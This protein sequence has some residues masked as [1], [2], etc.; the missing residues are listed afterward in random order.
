MDPH[1]LPFEVGQL[2][3]TRSFLAGYRGAWFRCKIKEIGRRNKELG[4]ALEY[5]DFPDESSVAAT[6]P[7]PSLSHA[8]FQLG[9][10]LWILQCL[11]SVPGNQKNWS[12]GNIG[13]SKDGKRTLMVRPCFPPVYREN[14]MPDV[15]TISEVIVIINDVWKVGDLVDWWIDNC[16]WSGRITEKLGDE[17]VKI[18]LPPPPVGEGSSYEVLC[19]DL[20]PSLDWSVSEGWKLLLPKVAALHSFSSLAFLSDLILV[21]SRLSIS[22]EFVQHP[23]SIDARRHNNLISLEFKKQFFGAKYVL[24]SVDIFYPIMSKENKYHLCCARIV[25]SLNRGGSPN[26]IDHT[27]SVRDKDAQ[28]TA[29]ASVEHEGSLSSHIS[30]GPLHLPYKRLQL[31][32]KSLNEKQT[33]TKEKIIGLTVV[34]HVPRKT[35]CSDSVSSSPIQDTS[36]QMP[37]MAIQSDK[38][39][40]N[41]LKKMKI[42]ERI[43]LNSTSSDTIEAAILD[44]EELICRVKWL[45]HILE[46]GTP[47]SDSMKSSWKFIEHRASRPK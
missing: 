16:F 26:L 33:K 27:F 4:H 42:D 2:V 37:G 9:G 28:P 21:F 25:K 8:S 22:F 45:K 7:C 46:F 38:Y 36:T 5:I 40:D 3:E 13:N 34:D 44:L 20:R 10:F 19:K 32:K 24:S 14:Q 11:L 41:G 18:E 43:C 17:K 29:G 35:S 47:L 30:S 39:D 15:N 31:A 12:F 23:I 1:S 6:F